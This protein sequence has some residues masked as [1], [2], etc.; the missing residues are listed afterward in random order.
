MNLIVRNI[1]KK[2]SNKSILS[3][4]NFTFSTGIYGILG[5]NGMGKTTFLSIITGNIDADSGE[6]IYNNRNI[7]DNKRGYLSDLGFLPQDFSYY[8]EFSGFEFLQYMSLLKGIK[9]KH[10]RLECER[11]INLVG[12]EMVKNKK[13]RTYS[14]GMKQRLGIGQ[15]L[16]GNP[17][18]IILD[19]P[20]VGLDP[21][22]RVKLRNLLTQLSKDRIILLSTH[23]V[24]DLMC[25]ADQ[26]L[27]LKDGN[28]VESGS[29]SNL[30][31]KFSNKIWEIS[32]DDIT[33]LR[34]EQIT[35]LNKSMSAPGNKFRIFSETKPSKCSKSINPTLEDI[36]LYYFSGSE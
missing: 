26:I 8:S 34:N 15:A 28:F 25:F 23:I 9:K 4:I 36:Y 16:I 35:I 17:K 33:K 24:N 27:I 14:G 12:L 10:Q 31:N 3:G 22:E 20:T 6:I 18:I 1:F 7:K 5:A 19:E 11:I 32:T 29:I 13:I 2:Y 30:L 21:K